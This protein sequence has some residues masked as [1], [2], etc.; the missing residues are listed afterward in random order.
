MVTKHRDQCSSLDIPEEDREELRWPSSTYI[1]WDIKI[2]FGT[3]KGTQ[4]KK[5]VRGIQGGGEELVVDIEELL[6][7]RFFFYLELELYP[8]QLTITL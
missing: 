6:L 2:P 3:R 7:S 5:Q 4:L 8:P 1:Y